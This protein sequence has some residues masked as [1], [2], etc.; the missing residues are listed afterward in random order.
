MNG[1]QAMPSPG[2]SLAFVYDYAGKQGCEDDKSS[3]T[4]ANAIKFTPGGMMPV[5]AHGP[6]WHDNFVLIH[7]VV[8]IV[9]PLV[10]RFLMTNCP[11]WFVPGFQPK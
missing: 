11:P 3:F 7:V 1:P 9:L 8:V 2:S 4:L 5:Y 6:R 10:C